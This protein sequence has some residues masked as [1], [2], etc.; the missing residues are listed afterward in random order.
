VASPIIY[1]INIITLTW[2]GAAAGTSAIKQY[3]I[4]Q[5]TSADGA[6]WQ[7]LRRW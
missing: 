7:A 3:V 4:Q 2:S 5:S 6:V 1:E